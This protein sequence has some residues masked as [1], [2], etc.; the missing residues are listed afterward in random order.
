MMNAKKYSKVRSVCEFSGRGI[1]LIS[2]LFL[3]AL[4]NAQPVPLFSASYKV[5]YG[6]LRGEM[7]LELRRTGDAEYVYE[8]SLSPRG[9]VTLF[10]RGSIVETTSLRIEDGR[11][12]PV[13]YRSTDTIAHPTRNTVYRF[14][15]PPG[16]VTGVYK[17][18]TVD[19]PMR[20]DGQNRISAHVAVMLAMNAGADMTAISVFDRA[21]WRDFEFEVFPGQAV[22]T[23]L[24]EFDTAE[25]RYASEDK[26]KSWSL[27]CAQALDYAPVMIVYREDGDVKSKAQLIEFESLDNRAPDKP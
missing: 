13:D 16:R 21:R 12:V 25:I 18:N 2:V 9:F 22:D 11:L 24:G 4:A 17:Q 26:D 14:D 3:A 8:T 7:T 20:P 23:K 19:E 27:Y 5:S 10:R 15:D 6:I 1:T